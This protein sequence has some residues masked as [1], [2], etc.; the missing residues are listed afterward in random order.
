MKCPECGNKLKKF[1]TFASDKKFLYECPVCTITCATRK[2]LKN[3][4][5]YKRK[6]KNDDR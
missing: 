3:A 1:K 2:T 4:W 6:E 5:K